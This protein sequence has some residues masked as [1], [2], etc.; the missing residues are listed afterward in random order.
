M[1]EEEFYRWLGRYIKEL[2]KKK[3]RTQHE[4]CHAFRLSRSSL[5]NIET[6]RH[7]LSIFALYELLCLLDEPFENMIDSMLVLRR[8]SKL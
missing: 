6:G 7:R 4:I 2:R 5:S 8:Q 1:S 3:N